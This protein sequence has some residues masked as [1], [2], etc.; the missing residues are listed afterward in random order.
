MTACQE[1]EFGS[2]IAGQASHFISLGPFLRAPFIG[3]AKL[4]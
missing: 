3:V 4:G 1:N 2:R